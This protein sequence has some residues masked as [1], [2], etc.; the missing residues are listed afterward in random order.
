MTQLEGS[1]SSLMRAFVVCAFA[2]PASAPLPVV[3]WHGMGDNCCMP[4]S[5][6]AI[7]AEVAKTGAFV[8]SIRIGR[9]AAEDEVEGFFGNMNHQVAGP[10]LKGCYSNTWELV[11][12]FSQPCAA[13]SSLSAEC[14]K[15]KEQRREASW[16]N[17]NIFTPHGT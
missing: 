9:N 5:M 1:T 7:Q 11:V 13:L 3:L 14:L 16:S 4:F 15:M 17:V 12:F 2:F 6:G 10:G 8:H